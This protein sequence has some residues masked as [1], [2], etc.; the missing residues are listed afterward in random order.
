MSK[1]A[2]LYYFRIRSLRRVSFQQT[3]R[4]VI[5]GTRYRNIHKTRR[6]SGNLKVLW[7]FRLQM[8]PFS[9]FQ[10]KTI[11]VFEKHYNLAQNRTVIPGVNY[12]FAIRL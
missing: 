2:F 1:N 3:A 8:F 12:R 9:L 11:R 7:F 6:G 4:S 5:R 10:P